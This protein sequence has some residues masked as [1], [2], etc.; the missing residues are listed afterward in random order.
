MPEQLLGRIIRVSSN[1]GETVLDPFSGSATTAAV[2]KKLG[3][4]YIAFDLSDDY[5]TYGRQRLESISSGDRLDGAPEP[6]V[7]APTTANGKQRGEP[8]P[9]K[10]KPAAQQ[11]TIF[12]T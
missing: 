9:R 1:D 7:S 5:V 10:K 12:E 6:L 8:R 4:R 3:R 2:A 11:R